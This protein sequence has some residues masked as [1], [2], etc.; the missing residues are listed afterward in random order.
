MW[1]R[2]CGLF[3]EWVYAGNSVKPLSAELPY[4]W[5][6]FPELAMYYGNENNTDNNTCNIDKH[7]DYV[8]KYFKGTIY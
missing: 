8:F 6:K 7:Q 2:S 3:E 4:K 5:Q 1:E